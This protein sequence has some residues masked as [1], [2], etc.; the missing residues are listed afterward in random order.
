MTSSKN[1]TIGLVFA[2]VFLVATNV[3]ADTVTYYDYGLQTADTYAWQ[4][5]TLLQQGD[6]GYSNPGTSGSGNN[7]VYSGGTRWNDIKGT[8][9]KDW[10]KADWNSAA[11]GERNTWKDGGQGWVAGVNHGN[12]WDGTGNNANNNIL[13]GFYA[14]SYTLTAKD[15]A[16]SSVNGT[17]NLTMGADDYV[18]AIY[19]NGTQIYGLGNTIY[20][21]EDWVTLVDKA[22]DVELI[23]GA[24]D[25][26]FVVH[27]T[28][29]G[30][31]ATLLNAMGLFVNGTLT[32]SIEMVPPPTTTPE[33]ATLA[34]LGLGLAG[35]GVARRRMKK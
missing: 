33:P 20:R 16:A 6:K 35:L 26:I 24:L 18:A 10:T 30:G 12:L 31:T 3:Q 25:L 19:A 1:F 11:V 14:Y 32:T 27:N 9:E 34:V 13:N 8:W 21:N 2:V 17:L 23:N 29:W 15:S 28:N 22:F 5:A 4:V 7:A